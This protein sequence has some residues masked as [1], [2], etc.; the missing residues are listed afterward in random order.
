MSDDRA[1]AKTNMWL[2]RPSQVRKVFR[3]SEGEGETIA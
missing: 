2:P 3:Y 1:G